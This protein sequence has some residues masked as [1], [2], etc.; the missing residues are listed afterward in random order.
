MQAQLIQQVNRQRGTLDEQQERLV[1]LEHD[2]L[3]WEERLRRRLDE[4]RQMLNRE[5]TQLEERCR[6][7][8]SQV[9]RAGHARRY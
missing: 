5:L 6:T 8:E 4:E 3:E 2:L 9:K 1:Q 7:Q